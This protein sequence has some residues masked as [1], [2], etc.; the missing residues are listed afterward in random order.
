MRVPKVILMASLL[1]TPVVAQG[2][3]VPPQQQDSGL[4]GLATGQT[5]RFSVLY[6]GIP[7]P[8]A[9]VGVLITLIID[10]D[11]GRTLVSQDFALTGGIGGKAAS[12][13]VNA[14][15]IMPAGMSKLL[16]HA[17]TLMPGNSTGWFPLVIPGLDIVDN[18][19]GRTSVHLETRV[20]YPREVDSR[21]CRR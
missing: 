7:A 16:I 6:P 15:A 11:Q 14:D 17:Y 1:A 12:V 9:Q 21:V 20:T 10:D 5:A 4:V 3:F 13:S 8:V 19:T 18:A 2:N